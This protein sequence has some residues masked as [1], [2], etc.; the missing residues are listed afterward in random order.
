MRAS[1]QFIFGADVVGFLIPEQ[2]P[3]IMV[4]RIIDYRSSPYPQ[5][6]AERYISANEPVF[7]GHFPDLK[8]WPGVHTIEGLRQSCG[9][10]D[11]VRQLDEANL[12]SGLLALQN[13]QTLRPQVNEALCQ[14]VLDTL[15]GMPRPD[16]SLLTLRVKLLTPVFAGCVINYQ[17]RQLR[18][19]TQSWSVQAKV[20]NITVAKGSIARSPAGVSV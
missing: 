1:G 2:Y 5:L 18:L 20:D 14:R 17:V 10:L 9:L 8:L 13:R 19:D 4:D 16:P 15:E 6:S 7:A 3:M 12:L 11:L